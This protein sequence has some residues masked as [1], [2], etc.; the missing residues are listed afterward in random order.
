MGEPGMANVTTRAAVGESGAHGAPH[1]VTRVTYACMM[2][3]TCSVCM[4][5]VHAGA[6]AGGGADPREGA[7]HGVQATAPRRRRQ[8]RPARA[9]GQAALPPFPAV[10]AARRVTARGEGCNPTWWRL[11]PHA[12]SLPTPCT[13]AVTPMCPVYH[14]ICPAFPRYVPRSPELRAGAPSPWPS[15]WPSCEGLAPQQAQSAVL[16]VPQLLMSRDSPGSWLRSAR[17]R[18]ASG[19]IRCFQQPASTSRRFLCL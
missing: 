5:G 16:V 7:L 19:T 4:H 12:L 11:Q 14:P 10:C 8:A 13:Q 9:R 15:L 17:Q 6:A 18:N 3:D 1:C 2:C